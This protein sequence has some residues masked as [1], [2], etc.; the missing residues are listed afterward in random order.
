MAP[1]CTAGAHAPGLAAP[2]QATNDTAHVSSAGR[3]G[4]QESR[5]DS[6][7][8]RQADQAMLLIEGESYARAWLG[9]LHG[10]TAQPGELAE[11]VEFLRG[12]PMLAGAARAI[13]KALEGARHA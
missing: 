9:R 8:P 2:E 7:C 1:H 6:R 12:G 11:L 4:E 3:S 5:S 10:G 13:E